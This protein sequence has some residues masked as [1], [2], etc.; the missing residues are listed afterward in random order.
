L[1]PSR[2]K[3][4][5]IVFEMS[6][7]KEVII[8]VV[9]PVIA[10]DESVVSSGDE[11]LIA[12]MDEN[13]EEFQ[14]YSVVHYDSTCVTNDFLN[15]PDDIKRGIYYQ[16]F[17]G[18]PE[19]G[20]FVVNEASN[21]LMEFGTVYALKRTWGEKFNWS[22]T[23][24]QIE[25][26]CYQEEDTF[27]KH[28]VK[29]IRLWK[30]CPPP[31]FKVA[32]D[33]EDTACS[34]INYKKLS[35]PFFLMGAPGIAA[36]RTSVAW[37]QRPKEIDRKFLRRVAQK[38]SD[39]QLRDWDWEGFRKNLIE[40]NFNHIQIVNK[41]T[42]PKIMS[43]WIDDLYVFLNNAGDKDIVE[44]KRGHPDKIH[45]VPSLNNLFNPADIEY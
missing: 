12:R 19:G 35:L 8:S 25:H 10:D 44:R 6:D 11:E 22:T 18:G 4:L 31:R 37:L 17:G 29:H 21:P 16:T 24:K 45:L 3:Y 36:A 26:Q 1:K 5:G 32:K 30:E 13:F 28:N 15:A 2:Q 39:N 43:R 20:Y 23:T 27:I 38:L 33:W 34:P 14:V 41:I 42:N 7:I 40:P 9:E